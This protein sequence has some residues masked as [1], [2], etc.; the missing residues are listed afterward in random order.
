MNRICIYHSRDL[1]GYCSGAIVKHKFPNVQLIGFDYGETLPELDLAPDGSTEV[2]MVD[3][4]IP[5]VEM[6]ALARKC[7]LTFIDHHRTAIQALEKFADDNANVRPGTMSRNPFGIS[8]STTMIAFLKDGLAACELTWM[9][10]F[11]EYAM[12]RTVELLGKYDTWRNSDPVEWENI[13]LPFQY[14]MRMVCSGPDTMPK[15]L[16]ATQNQATAKDIDRILSDGKLI[17]RYQKE[18]N[19]ITCK[20]AFELEFKGYRAIAL[21]GGGFSS[22]TFQSVWDESKYDLMVN[23]AFNGKFWTVSLY[24]TKDIDCSALA[25]EMGGGGHK[26]AAGFQLN[27]VRSLI[28]FAH[29]N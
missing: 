24:T 7:K 4:S 19:A 13:I 9:Y 11:R 10:F 25:K 27:D 26:Q 14:G 28:G 20:R 3:V 21:N 12:P 2:I 6:A 5:P 23:F 16:L 8:W 18:Q 15:N 17:L 29:G 1:D 22:L